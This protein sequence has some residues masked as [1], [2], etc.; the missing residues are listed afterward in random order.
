MAVFMNVQEAGVVRSFYGSY[1]PE[2]NSSNIS[3][4][5]ARGTARFIEYAR[6][7]GYL[8]PSSIKTSE[9][10]LARLPSDL[11]KMTNKILEENSRE[12]LAA[13]KRHN[14]KLTTIDEET[15]DWIGDSRHMIHE[16][17]L[18]AEQLTD[19]EIKCLVDCFPNLR[20]LK[21]A[22]NYKITN[23]TLSLLTG[24]PHLESLDL[25][26]CYGITGAGL[27]AIAKLPRLRSLDL[28]GCAIPEEA[29][30]ELAKLV[31]LESVAVRSFRGTSVNI[32]LPWLAS[33]PN[34]RS[35]TLRD[36]N[37]P[38][39]TL[40]NIAKLTKLCSLHLGWCTI[41]GSG[42]SRLAQLPHLHSLDF[43]LSTIKDE[44]VLELAKLS[45][46]KSLNLGCSSKVMLDTV[47]NLRRLRPDVT[48]TRS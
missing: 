44:A 33:L 29:F 21:L 4:S 16:L 43:S 1:L 10:L 2:V 34:L 38:E 30:S 31:R 48:V 7:Q 14:Y 46:L 22:R 41:E 17:D 3:I 42:V 35:L 24:L 37:I 32:G 18:T 23:D 15:L 28:C 5:A 8:N 26:C 20:S 9:D 45:K 40:L 27:T 6:I 19:I 25:Q 11:Q 13:L 12:V 47:D 39:A 36:Y